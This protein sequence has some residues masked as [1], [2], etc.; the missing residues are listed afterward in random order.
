M[1]SQS[2]LPDTSEY[3]TTEAVISGWLGYPEEVMARLPREQRLNV[4]IK[5]HSPEPLFPGVLHEHSSTK[6]IELAEKVHFLESQLQCDRP[7]LQLYRLG[8]GGLL[9]AV[10]SLVVWVIT[11]IGIPFHPMFAAGVIPLSIAVIVMAFLIRPTSASSE[12]GNQ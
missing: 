6:T 8:A 11:G 3:Y 1:L 5:P 9:G 10:T 7:Y 4:W 12:K 2:T